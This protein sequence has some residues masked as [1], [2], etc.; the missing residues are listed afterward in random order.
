MFHMYYSACVQ[1]VCVCVCVCSACSTGTMHVHARIE[2]LHVC[3]HIPSLAC[4]CMSLILSR[5]EHVSTFVG[6]Y[7]DLSVYLHALGTES[8]FAFV[9]LYQELGACIKSW[10]GIC[11]CL[12]VPRTDRCVCICQH[13]LRAERVPACV[14]MSEAYCQTQAGNIRCYSV[15][16]NSSS[17]GLQSHMPLCNR[18]YLRGIMQSR[19]WAG[20]D[21]F[22]LV[23]SADVAWGIQAQTRNQ[24]ALENTA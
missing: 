8:V 2:G 12:Q 11:M 18:Y 4:F 23:H 14:C 7:Q 22:V 20:L 17:S 24:T 13:S 1:C 9:G 16:I 19:A 10:A 15:I 21:G 5:A 3:E 6:S